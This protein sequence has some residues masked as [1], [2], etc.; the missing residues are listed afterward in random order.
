MDLS[1]P[2]ATISAPL[3]GRVLETLSGT[4]LPLSGREIHRITGFGSVAGVWKVLAR[5]EQQGVVVAD[6]RLKLTHYVGN[7]EHLAWPAIESLVG[8]RSALFERIRAE[9]Q[10]WTVPPIHAS[11]FGSAARRDADAESDVDLLLVCEDSLAPIHLETW[12]HQLARLREQVRTWT[13]NN[14]QTLAISRRRFGQ[15]VAA[16]D[17]MVKEWERDS[18]L[19][20][21]EPVSTLIRRA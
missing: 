4:T 16:R 20:A 9:I 12:E 10:A 6:H 1:N 3:T 19:I 17:P 21:G 8:L 15:H 11:V 2:A 14:C 13:G 18:V 7:R 5:L